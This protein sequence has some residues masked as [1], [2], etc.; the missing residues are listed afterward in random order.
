MPI[1]MICATEVI[2]YNVC[3]YMLLVI[4][5]LLLVVVTVQG[6]WNLGRIKIK[7]CM[8]SGSQEIS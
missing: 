4:Y 3:D 1:S 2:L 7:C 5:V 8:N 6:R